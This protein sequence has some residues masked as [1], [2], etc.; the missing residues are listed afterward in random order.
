MEEHTGHSYT[1]GHSG[2]YHFAEQKKELSENNFRM[3]MK[4]ANK[5]AYPLPIAGATDGCIYNAGDATGGEGIGL[6][7]REYFA[8]HADIPWNAVIDSL[9][10]KYDNK[11]VLTIKEVIAYRVQMKLM[12]ADE[13]L[14]Q[15]ETNP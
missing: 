5:S 13:L 4:N 6:T 1:E 14:K 15:L 2:G 9:E 3:N 10:K 8:A 11:V 12:E 7:K